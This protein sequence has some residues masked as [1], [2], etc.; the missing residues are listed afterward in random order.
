MNPGF[1][2]ES[3]KRIEVGGAVELLVDDPSFASW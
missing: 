3:R 1:Y 2:K